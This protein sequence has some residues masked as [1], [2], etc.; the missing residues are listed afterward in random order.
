[1]YIAGLVVFYELNQ[2]IKVNGRV[3]KK[4][5]RLGKKQIEDANF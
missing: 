4:K 2:K 5:G 3:Q 1:M